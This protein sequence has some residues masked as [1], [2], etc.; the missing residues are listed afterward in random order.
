MRLKSYFAA[1]V[2]EAIENARVELG[3]EAML[4][5][6]REIAPEQRHL[7]AYEVVFGI[8]GEPLLPRRSEAVAHLFTASPASGTSPSTAAAVPP[9]AAKSPAKPL[10]LGL[11]QFVPPAAAPPAAESASPSPA[12]EIPSWKRT[13]EELV[14]RQEAPVPVSSIAPPRATA[15]PFAQ[16]RP[17]DLASRPAAQEPATS[18]PE[19]RSSPAARATSSVSKP[20][21]RQEATSRTDSP[22]I[23]ARLAAQAAAAGVDT[24]RSSSARPPSLPS[25]ESTPSPEALADELV[26]LRQQI[27]R[28]KSSLASTSHPAAP[29]N[30]P[31]EL[32]LLNAQ[33]IGLGFSPAFAQK[34]GDAAVER[35]A[36][37]SAESASLSYL[38][39]SGYSLEHLQ[40]VLI[41]ELQSRFQVRP[42]L[43]VTGSDRKTV[44]F[45]GPPGAG[46]TT[47]LVKLAI[48]YGMERRLPVHLLSLDTVRVGGSEQLG[49][50]ARILNVGFD[51]LHTTAALRE[52]LGDCRTDQI[53]LIDCPG[54]APADMEQASA[55]AS[56]LRQNPDV[57]VQLVLPAF[58]NA[59]SLQAS[60]QRF[61]MFEPSKLIYTHLDEVDSLGTI[62]EHTVKASLPVSFLT[63]GQGI[64]Q[65]LQ[66]AAKDRFTQ[67]ILNGAAAF[68]AA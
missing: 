20:G 44:M 38:S 60:S 36:A 63:N 2:A 39:R 33:M 45:V 59:S 19:P 37:F 10:G 42:D 31:R 18:S 1:S 46:K 28:V 41:A 7:G 54:Y 65:D 47:T 24:P 50:F 16:A 14:S 51:A 62:L 35:L 6:S 9:A 34:M 55:T 27:E 26:S 57:D 5:N 3:P 8:T 67:G 15:V 58:M 30:R 49:T 40:Q 32:D 12:P 56:F 43:G 29:P 48:K 52:A 68:G 61:S 53:V 17:T 66:E 21:N 11:R 25:G 22:Q 4:L 13:L 23:S 64:P